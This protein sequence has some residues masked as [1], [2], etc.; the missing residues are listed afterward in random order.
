MCKHLSTT[1][2]M[3]PYIIQCNNCPKQ[4]SESEWTDLKDIEDRG[5]DSGKEFVRQYE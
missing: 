5:D 1:A 2:T 4:W 3:N